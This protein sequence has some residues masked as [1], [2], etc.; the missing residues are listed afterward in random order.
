METIIYPTGVDMEVFVGP[1]TLELDADGLPRL[2]AQAEPLDITGITFIEESGVLPLFNYYDYLPTGV[3]YATRLVSGAMQFNF[4][5]R[6][7]ERHRR[8]GLRGRQA[9]QG[10]TL[11]VV[12][13]KLDHAALRED[14]TIGPRIVQEIVRLNHVWEHPFQHV[15]EPT[16]TE[17]VP[18]TAHSLTLVERQTADLRDD[19]A[20]EFVQNPDTFTVDGE[21]PYRLV[22]RSYVATIQPNGARE[23]FTDGDT[24]YAHATI[25]GEEVKLKVRLAMADT[26]ETP[27][28]GDWVGKGNENINARWRWPDPILLPDGTLHPN[29]GKYPT[30][31]EL[32]DWGCTAWQAAARWVADRGGK[33]LLV[34]D[35]AS[36]PTDNPNARRDATAFYREALRDI[37]GMDSDYAEPRYLFQIKS[38]Q[39]EDLEEYLIRE[40]LAVPLDMPATSGRY[41]RLQQLYREAKA[42]AGTPAAKGIWSS[43][44]APVKCRT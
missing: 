44:T 28:T 3:A 4:S 13:R 14:G 25:G 9:L 20:I 29:S 33:V 6:H 38:L 16:A 42:K 12:M 18:F 10:A 24:L 15:P 23:G 41:A 7:L 34:V 11:Y 31:E 27:K 36:P 43:F 26:P 2:S 32:Y 30:A 22:E 35:P 8:G 21:S 1:E 17:T 19:L 39:G 37:T 5:R 40:G